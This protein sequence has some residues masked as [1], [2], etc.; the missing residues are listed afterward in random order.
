MNGSNFIFD[1]VDSSQQNCRKINM[2]KKLQATINPIDI[3][4]DKYFQYNA[5]LALNHKEI[6]QKF[7][8]NIHN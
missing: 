3:L 6:G 1:C 7:R 2:K 4:E 8:K 5:M